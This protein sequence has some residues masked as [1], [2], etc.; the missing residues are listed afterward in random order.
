MACESMLSHLEVSPSL[1][2]PLPYSHLYGEYSG[3]ILMQPLQMFAI[4]STWYN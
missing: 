1:L 4:T 3:P 2:Y